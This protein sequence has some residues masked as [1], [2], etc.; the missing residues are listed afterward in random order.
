M[1]I[2]YIINI[3]INIKIMFLN[4]LTNSLNIIVIKA[5]IEELIKL[6]KGKKIYYYM[7]SSLVIF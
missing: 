6:S 4:N 7:H 5:I 3:S 2:F 1:G